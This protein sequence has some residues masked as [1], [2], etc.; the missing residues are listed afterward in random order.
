MNGRRVL[1]VV[2]EQKRT[3][4]GVLHNES[5][6]RRTSFIEPEETTELNN[7]IASLEYEETKE[8]YRI[9][10]VLT[11]QMNVYAPLLK[12][13]HD[14]AGEYDFIRAKGKLA[15]D[16]NAAHPLLKDRAHIHLIK[17]YHPLL[18]LFNKNNSKPTFPTDILSER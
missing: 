5:D 17:A 11:Q 3:V 12:S 13:Y 15:A 18:Y 7:E 10:R 4:K 2:A 9:L 1:A 14:I 8:V 6:S 16:M